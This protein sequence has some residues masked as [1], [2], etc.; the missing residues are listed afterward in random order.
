MESCCK[1]RP[2]TSR[3]SKK[4]T[5]AAPASPKQES[6]C[7]PAQSRHFRPNC[8]EREAA[9]VRASRVPS[10]RTAAGALVHA[11]T[12][13]KKKAASGAAFDRSEAA[14]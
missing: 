1:W 4:R 13:G 5:I 14:R 6:L 3:C 9:R 2:V 7:K 11:P 8:G 10:R 12:P